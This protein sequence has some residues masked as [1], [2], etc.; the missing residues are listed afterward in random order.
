MRDRQ[1]VGRKSGG[2]DQIGETRQ[3]REIR[4]RCPTAPPGTSAGAAISG[5]RRDAVGYMIA[6]SLFG[7]Q[8][9]R[10][11][12]RAR[13]AARGRAPTCIDSR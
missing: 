4:S 9:R 5:G 7:L 1:I 13:A 12:P 11:A 10:S 6:S 3:V 8:A 2:H